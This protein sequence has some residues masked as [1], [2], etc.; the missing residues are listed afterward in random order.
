[1]KILR[2]ILMSLA[3]AA[4]P[5]FI[6]MTMI[7]LL[8]TPLSLDIEYKLPNFPPD[9]YGFTTA[10]RLHWGKI[11]LQY[12]MQNKD[13]TF[14]TQQ[15]LPD[16]QPLYNERELGHMVDVQKLLQLMIK[17]WIGMGI[18]LLLVSILV[19]RLKWLD[20][21]LMALSTGGWITV[22]LIGLILVGIFAGFSAF[23]TDF[24]ELFFTGNTWL[25]Y[26]SDS[27]I[28]LFPLKLW[29]DG[30]T[31]AGVLSGLVGLLVAFLPRRWVHD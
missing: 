17:V 19:W 26:Y 14:L 16:G 24:H 5:L 8:F 25:F 28:R 1:M 2:V 30:F 4:T 18:Y 27:L 22:G 3:A 20:S 23:F 13:I 15:K 29:Q 10:D 7:R 21:F 6:M 11:S 31:A 9:E 12:L